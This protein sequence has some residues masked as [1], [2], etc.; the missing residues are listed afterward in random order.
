M[1]PNSQEDGLMKKSIR[2]AMIIQDYLPLGGGAERQLAALGPLLQEQQVEIHILT[3]RYT[4]LLP[5]EFIDGLPVHRLPII[6]PRS[7]L[8]SLMF[9][10]TAQPVL[11]R[12]QPD[13]I[14]AHGLL[15]PTTVAVAAKRRLG[16]PL[17]AKIL[18]GGRFGDLDRLKRKPF[19]QRR[20][21][22]F[23]KQ[24]DAFVTIS[25]EIDEELSNIG[26][27]PEKR[28]FI[29]NG[30]DLE[31]FQPVPLPQKRALRSP[32]GL[33]DG[34]IVI[35]TGRLEP[36]KCLDQLIEMWPS[37]RISQPDALL[38]ILGT[39]AEEAK[40]RQMAG[41]GILF[42]G[43][44]D[45]VAG[46]LQASDIFVLPSATEGLSNALLEAMASGLPAIATAVGGA[47]DLIEH[48]QNGWLIPPDKPVE[49]QEALLILL[50]NP[51]FRHNF[52]CQSRKKI[53]E[54]YA[55]PVTARHL[56]LLYD[57]L[58]VN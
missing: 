39:G 23:R 12:L 17:V 33:P 2:V 58:L 31:R 4:G 44:V 34:P 18:R 47:P 56:R 32:L 11:K 6:K 51:T 55:L 38:L 52:G 50:N 22:L 13:L 49:L 20:I 9:T 1:Y 5:F 26:V 42:L 14:H 41:E 53:V 28:F 25:Q 57:Q 15:S 19:G 7:F 3:R 37:V 35:Y 30:V 29:P 8:A 27:S 21:R 54:N 10:L 46:Y 45:N 43:H 16:A 40:L 36:E 24:V 48:C